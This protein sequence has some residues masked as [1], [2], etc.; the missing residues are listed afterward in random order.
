[1]N[2]KEWLRLQEVRFK[3]LKR[4]F[5][6]EYSHLPAYVRKDLY[7][8]RVGHT[9]NNLVS[10]PTLQVTTNMDGTIPDGGSS[11]VPRDAASKIFQHAS[12]KDTDFSPKPIMIK[13]SPLDFTEN[14]LRIFMDRLFGFKEDS[15]I[16]DD[17]Q[18]NI[19][20]RGLLGPG[21]NTEPV[22]MIRRGDKFEL[23]E[24]WHRTMASLV[25]DGNDEIGAPP[26][27]IVMLKSGQLVPMEQ[28]QIWKPVP[29]KAYLGVPR[30]IA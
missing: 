26:D 30:Q 16:R 24:G 25:F 7:N 2:F 22:I 5:D 6:K 4:M 8:T 19:I 23:L 12:Y 13:V 1:M 29:I 18:R 9:M 20:Q 27:H 3:G 17:A 21:G 28:L 15:R 14:C 10:D 11:E